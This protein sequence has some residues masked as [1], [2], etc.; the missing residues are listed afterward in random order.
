MEKLKGHRTI[1][2]AAASFIIPIAAAAG[3]ITLTPLQLQIYSMA[4]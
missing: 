2:V 4:V 1:I 3:V